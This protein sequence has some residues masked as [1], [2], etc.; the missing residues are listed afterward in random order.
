MRL[1]KLNWLML[2]SLFTVTTGAMSLTGALPSLSSIPVVAQTTSNRSAEA[3]QL[4]QQGNQQ[5][6][7]SQFRDALQSWQAALKLYREI[8]NR[9]G[10]AQSLGNLGL[11]Y[12][13]LGDYPKAIDF[14]Q[15]SLAIK[16]EIGYRL[17][18]ANSLGN[19]GIAY[20]SLGDYPKAIDFHQQSLAIQREIGNRLGEAQSLGNLG[21]AYNAL[22][23]Y[24]KAIDFHQQSLAI[25]REIG[26]RLGEAQS[27]GNL[28]LAYYSLGDYPKAIDFH[29]Q[30]LAISREIG[31]RLGEAQSLGSLGIAYDSLGDYPKAIDFHQQSLAIKR[32]IGYRLGEAQSLGSLGIAYYSLGDYP[33]AIDFHQQY[34][35]IS[36]EIGYRLGE[37]QSLGNLGNAYYSLG[38]Y[39]KAID[40][41]QQSLAINREIGNRLGEAQSLGNLGLAYDALGDYPKAIDFHQQYLAISREIGNQEGEGLALNNLAYTLDRMGETELAITFFKQSVNVREG[42][43]FRNF[44]LS[45]DLQQSYTQTVSGSY[46][47]L[48]DLL[49]EQGRI[50][51]AQKVLELL[52]LEELNE[53][54]RGI[55]SPKSLAQV[56]LNQVEKQIK[57]EHTSLVA[58]GNDFYNCEQKNCDQLDSLKTRYQNLSEAFFQ[59]V[60]E[61]VQRQKET[62]KTQVAKGTDDFLASRES[63][64]TAQ[65]HTLLIYPLVLEDKVRLLWASKG[66]VLGNEVCELGQSDLSKLVTQYQSLI[67]ERQEI[68][69]VKAVGQEL[70]DCLVKPLEPELQANQIRNLIFVPD[71]ITNYIPMGALF[72]GE[73]FLIQRYTVTNI[74][75]ASITDTRD[76]LPTAPSQV[77]VLGLGLSEA[78]PPFNALRHVPDEVDAIVRQD[79]EDDLGIFPG[80]AFMNPDFTRQALED[81]LRDRKILHIATHAEFVPATPKDSY[82]L[83]GTGTKYP[84]PRIRTLRHLNTVHLVVLSACE[85]AKGGPDHT[86]IEVAG[87]SS[88]FT[89]GQDKA[90]AVLASLWKV[91]DASTSTLMQQFYQ[92][93]ASG[94]MTKAAALQKAQIE[95]LTG[96]SSGNSSQ[97]RSSVDWQPGTGPQNKGIGGD[98]THPYYWAPFILIGNSL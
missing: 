24:P 56:Q 92:N 95:M 83:L 58:F 57:A 85:T 47:K 49:I 1:P 11:A 51:E 63:V 37:A 97:E 59:L 36:R 52:K 16:R 26:N 65:P 6:K 4:F 27:L 78:K 8:G 67:T 69:Q 72:D 90:K 35:A 31:Y 62:R 50:A 3:D 34:L 28:G 20:Y 71:R 77:P 86:G 93:L 75:A 74:L 91:N 44:N 7:S 82:F 43:R 13:S 17:G 79:Q 68:D 12:Y 21:I 48:A 29:Q 5:F 14:H 22:G 81:N 33:K 60:Q 25:E 40:F 41:H 66:G 80:K 54:T 88:F 32:E 70:Y 53:F 87:M 55:D 84:I 96:K 15:Q 19:L 73:Q 64:V 42:I 94:E 18:E 2:T 89:G 9:L 39:P 46:R 98:R 38:D 10:E 30:S 76:R 61:I 23:D 45:G